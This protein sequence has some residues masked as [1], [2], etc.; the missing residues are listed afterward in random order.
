MDG[1]ILRLAVS[2]TL[3]RCSCQRPRAPTLASVKKPSLKRGE[4]QGKTT[5]GVYING[6]SSLLHSDRSTIESTDS[7]MSAR[8]FCEVGSSARECCRVIGVEVSRTSRAA[9]ALLN[10]R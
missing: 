10:G 8:K 4:S 1:D 7:I 5:A 2:R 3:G 6:T 9:R